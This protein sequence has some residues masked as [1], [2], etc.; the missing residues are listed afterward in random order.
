MN[1]LPPNLD[2]IIVP[3]WIVIVIIGGALAWG[4]ITAIAIIGG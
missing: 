2:E 1:H 3:A 4:V